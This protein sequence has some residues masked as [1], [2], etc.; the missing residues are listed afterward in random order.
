METSLKQERYNKIGAYITTVFFHALV[1]LLLWTIVWGQPD[2]PL[3]KGGSE[4][5]LSLGFEDAGGPNIAPVEDPALQEPVPPTPDPEVAEQPVVTQDEG[6]ENTAIATPKNEPKKVEVKRPV[7]KPVVK[8]TVK[9]AEKPVEQPRKADEKSLFKKRTTTRVEDGGYGDGDKL[10]NQGSPD[11]HPDG[12]P[13]GNGYGDGLG[14]TGTGPGGGNGPGNGPGLGFVLNGR[15][16]ARKPVIEDNT[17][18]T[19]KVVVSIVVD[20]SGRVTKAMPNQK[21]TTT[22]NPVLLEKAKQAAL[23][24]RFSPKPDAPEEQFGTMT[25]IFKFKP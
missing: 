19:G 2:P 10:G 1:L 15:T 24:T 11:G 12:D 22:L 21:G 18:E 8:P 16:M 3:D 6:E 9:P 17:K 23:D 5:T 7:E 25:I 14:G 4:L 13:H 20:R